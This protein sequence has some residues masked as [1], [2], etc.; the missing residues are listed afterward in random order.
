MDVRSDDYDE[1]GEEEE[2]HVRLDGTDP[3]SRSGLGLLSAMQVLKVGADIEEAPAPVS[4]SQQVYW[5]YRRTL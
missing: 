4:W 2:G 1:E 3:A 5:F